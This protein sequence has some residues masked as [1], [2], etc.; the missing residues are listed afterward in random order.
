MLET[1]TKFEV[2]S[3]LGMDM[4][5]RFQIKDSD[6]GL[7]IFPIECIKRSIAVAKAYKSRDSTHYLAL[8]PR[9]NWSD[10][11]TSHIHHYRQ[12]TQHKTGEEINCGDDC[13]LTDGRDDCSQ[14]YDDE[15]VSSTCLKELDIEATSGEEYSNYENED[16]D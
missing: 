7:R 6:K 3:T 14:T 15:S 8:S 12:Q 2:I 5:R 10:L 16:S 1:G 9:E 11:F 13:S 4:I